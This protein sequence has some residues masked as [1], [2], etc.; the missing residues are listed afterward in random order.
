MKLRYLYR[1]FKARYRDEKSE[2]QAALAIIRPGD[3]VTDIG[4]NKGSYLYWMQKAVG[5]NGTVFAFEPQPKLAKY[6]ET[7]R[8]SMGWENVK[9][10]DCGLSDS[11]G[12][13]RLNVPGLK[14]SPGASLEA[15]A[16]SAGDSHSEECRVDTLDRQL[17]SQSRVSLLKMDVEGH[18]LNVFRGAKDILKRH[19]PALLFECEARHLRAH[20][21]ADVFDYLKSFGYAG[22]FFSPEGL[23]PL[24]EFSPARHQKT[25]GDRFWDAPDYC[26]N[27]LFV[28]ESETRR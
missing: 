5:K 22:S 18:E 1:T 7:V 24:A 3:T 2:I 12:T 21:M 23:R 6:L 19:A 28:S 9:V 11:T 13:G 8:R 14:D 15:M 10:C 27:F 26:N 25:E 16:V 4:A 20:S 17:A